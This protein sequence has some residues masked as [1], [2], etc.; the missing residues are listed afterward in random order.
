[1]LTRLLKQEHFRVDSRAE[2]AVFFRVRGDDRYRRLT[3][4]DYRALRSQFEANGRAHL[5]R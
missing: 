4:D 5:L 3:D 1:V 2:G